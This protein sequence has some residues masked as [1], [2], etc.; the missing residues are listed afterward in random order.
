M[1]NTNQTTEEIERLREDCSEAY[2]AA[3][4][5]ARC[6]GYWDMAEDDPRQ[7]Q[8][9][10]L[11]DNLAAASEGEPRPHPDLLPFGWQA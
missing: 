10:K 8:I 4:F 3:G 2:Q 5:L 11:L 1:D 7:A 6:L 9:T